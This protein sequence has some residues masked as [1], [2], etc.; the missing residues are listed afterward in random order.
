MPYPDIN[1]PNF[2]SKLNKK[3]DKFKIPNKKKSMNQICFP[4]EYK[5]QIPQQFLANY[6]NPKT[7]YK[8]ILIFHRIGAG[9]TCTAVNLC[10]QWKKHKKI[11]VVTPASLKGN[12]LNE[13]RSPCAGNNYLKNSERKQLQKL[14]P[15]DKEYKDI[16]K[17][18]DK[19]INKYYNVYSYNKFIELYNNDE[20]S[21]RNTLLVIDEIQNMVSEKGTYYQCLYNAIH[22]APNSLRVVLLSATPMFDKPIEIALT[23]NLLRIPFE[24]PIGNEFD[25]TFIKKSITHNGKYKYKAKNLDIFKERI[26]GFVS[27]Y[28][29]APPYVFPESKLRYVHCEMSDFQYKS[30]V[31]ALS[32]EENYIKRSI[33]KFRKG[34]ILDLPNS[35]FIGTRMISNIAFPNKGVGEKGYESF[36]KSC[37]SLDKLEQYSIKFYTIITK[38]LRSW[39]PVFIYSNFKEYGGIK[40]LTK[41][42]DY[43]GFKD[44]CKYGEGKKRYAIWSGDCKNELREEIKAV[45]NQKNN[46]NGSKIKIIIG[47]PSSKE[48]ISFYNVQQIHILEPYWNFSRMLQIIG[49]GVRYCSHK[50]LPEEKRKVKIY[51]YLATHPEE[52]ESIDEYIMNLAIKKHKL[53]TQFETALKESAVDC[54]LFKKGNVYKE[55]NEKDIKCDT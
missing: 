13:L 18:S 40:S 4:K 34:A 26:K 49:R 23:M 20:L 46:Y 53:I 15:S 51:V 22:N 27:Y 42:L 37:L 24:L 1:D 39:G 50:N 36:K 43:I 44:Y 2:Y 6:I 30:Y 45:F 32:T 47:S 19:R 35:F 7:P 55:N 3:F 38:I 41:V 29:G 16:I 14:H 48:G 9:K 28:R 12:F 54:K 11:I 10:E 31:T 33:Q 25:D 8:G 5:L 21:L 52:E 17:K